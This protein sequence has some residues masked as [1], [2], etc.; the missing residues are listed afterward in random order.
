MTRTVFFGKATNKQ[1]KMYQTVLE[2]QKRAIELLNTK[3]LILNT[4][5]KSIKASEIDKV[6]RDYIIS[7][8]YKTIPHSLGH[9]IGLE[10][11]ESPRLS[12]KSKDILKPGMV[13]TIEPGIYIPDFGGV[14]IEDV[15]L[16][17][18]SHTRL[19]TISSKDSTIL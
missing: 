12:P 18:E 8:N 5:K 15:V 2:A 11:H 13:F 14:R 16:L 19:L 17:E 9:G 7:K 10:V 4:S 1:K 3:Y 6:A